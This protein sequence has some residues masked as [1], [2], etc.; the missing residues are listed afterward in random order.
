MKTSTLAAVI[1]LSV[2]SFTASIRLPPQWCAKIAQLCDDFKDDHPALPFI[3]RVCYL[4]TLEQSLNEPILYLFPPVI[5][6]SPVEQFQDTLHVQIF[7]PKCIQLGKMD[8]PLHASGW[9]NALDGVRSEPRKIYGSE[10]ICLV[11]GRVY[12]CHNSHEVVGYHPGL[13]EQI[14]TNFI[15]FRLWHKTGFTTEFVD[16]IVALITTGLSISEIRNFVYKRHVSH[17]HGR[18]SQFN[19]ALISLK[20]NSSFPSLDAWEGCFPNVLPSIHAL[21]GCFLADFWNKDCIYT[22]CM[23]NMT[24]DEW[25]SLDHTFSSTSKSEWLASAT[26]LPIQ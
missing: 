19:K 7:C 12:R 26:V 9:R 8:I 5:M 15:P 18:N 23:Q 10:G 3:D 6:W 13:L 4:I 22:R 16:L 20:R 14:S 21:S 17:Y 25:L 24:I 11:I 2:V 1:F